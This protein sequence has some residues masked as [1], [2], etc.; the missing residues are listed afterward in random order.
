[1]AVLEAQILGMHSIDA[2]FWR[3]CDIKGP[4]SAVSRQKN[5][6]NPYVTAV[7]DYRTDAV[8]SALISTSVSSNPSVNGCIVW[9]PNF[10]A[11]G[12]TF[13]FSCPLELKIDPFF[14]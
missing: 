6:T 10:R 12:D 1:M 2:E 7:V 3:V 13:Q 5:V 9:T 14:T 8:P 4:I 11:F